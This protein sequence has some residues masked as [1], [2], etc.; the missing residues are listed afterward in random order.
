MTEQ[1]KTTLNLPIVRSENFVIKT[2]GTNN[3]EMKQCDVVKLVLKNRNK[4]FKIEVDALVTPL[5]CSPLKG[6]EV[7][8]AKETFPICLT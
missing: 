4:T 5:I 2:F 7:K 8:L 1:L 3:M 6:Q